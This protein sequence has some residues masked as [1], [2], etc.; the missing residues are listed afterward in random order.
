[1]IA[2][3]PETLGSME[4]WAR[5][6]SLPVMSSRATASWRLCELVEVRLEGTGHRLSLA[7]LRQARSVPASLSA[8]G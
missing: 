6:G 5:R 2:R 1:L 8:R 7:A 4:A 3:R